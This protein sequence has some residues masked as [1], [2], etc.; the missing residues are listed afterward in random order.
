[1]PLNFRDAIVRINNFVI[2][3]LDYLTLQS[4]SNF[5][6]HKAV[7]RLF[8]VD[9]PKAVDVWSILQTR[10][11]DS[12]SEQLDG[13]LQKAKVSESN[14]TAAC[15]DQL[16]QLSS[17]LGSRSNWAYRV[18]DAFGKPPSGIL[19]GNLDWYGEFTE[20]RNVS[21]LNG[22][23]TGRYALITKPIDPQDMFKPY[24]AKV[25]CP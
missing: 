25:R 5:T 6:V 19:S 9:Q 4:Q 21:A 15:L 16:Q 7:A 1:M 8:N 22:S 14:I 24:A 3:S 12:L 13:S 20:C 10:G 17:G 23:W 18:L 2:V 11:I